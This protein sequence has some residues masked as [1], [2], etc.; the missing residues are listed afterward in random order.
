[1]NETTDAAIRAYQHRCFAEYAA[2]IEGERLLP[3]HYCYP[4]GNPIRPLP[5]VRTH[6][7]GLMIIGAYPSARFESRKSSTTNA[8]R[9]I[10]IADNLEP[11]GDEVYFDGL[12][13]RHLE[14]GIGLRKYLLDPLDLAPEDCWIT[15]L[16]KV[17]LFKEDHA[18]SCGEVVPK[19]KVPVLRDQFMRLGQKSLPWIQEEMELC[20]P[21]AI[22]TL[23]EEVARIISGTALSADK[24]LVPQPQEPES[25]NKKLT[26]YCPHPDACRRSEKWRGKMGEM[27]KVIA[28]ALE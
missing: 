8:Y 23:G 20:Q 19:F 5:P 18:E 12:R 15:D 11:F 16:V 17:F 9:L 4:T 10:P 28:A 13:V 1:M 24:L 21:K 22:V 27:V 3:A 25:L 7:G 6:T 14:S 2:S 26:F